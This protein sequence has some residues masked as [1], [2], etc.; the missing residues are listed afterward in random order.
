MINCA[1]PAT[2]FLDRCFDV[3][4]VTDLDALVEISAF[5]KKKKRKKN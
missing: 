4:V 5:K 3:F 1:V 2:E